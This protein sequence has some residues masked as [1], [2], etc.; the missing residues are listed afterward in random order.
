MVPRLGDDCILFWLDRSSFSAYTETYCS[1]SKGPSLSVVLGVFGVFGSPE[2]SPV[3]G[4]C[5]TVRVRWSDKE[6]APQHPERGGFHVAWPPEGR[7]G[8]TLDDGLKE[9]AASASG[10]RWGGKDRLLVILYSE[11]QVINH[12]R[13]SIDSI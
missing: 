12:H 8:W 13:A 1:S 11:C 6:F 10:A 9:P 5:G 7:N 4:V 3:P 2:P